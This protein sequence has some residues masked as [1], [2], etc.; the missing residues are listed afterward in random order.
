MCVYLVEKSGAMRVEPARHT[1][2]IGLPP[3]EMSLDA[4]AHHASQLLKPLEVTLTAWVLAPKLFLE[5][6]QTSAI[7]SKVIWVRS[8]CVSSISV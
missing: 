4:C 5:P 3:Y 2:L 8:F 1:Q 7:M 6:H